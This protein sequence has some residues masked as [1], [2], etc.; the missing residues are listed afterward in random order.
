MVYL[1]C[2]C[3]LLLPYLS[4][5]PFLASPWSVSVRR[6][7]PMM[8]WAIIPP[9]LLLFHRFRNVI[10]LRCSAAEP[11]GNVTRCYFVFVPAGMR[12]FRFAGFCSF[13]LS[14]GPQLLRSLWMVVSGGGGGS[15]AT[16]GIACINVSG[17]NGICIARL[18]AGKLQTGPNSRCWGYMRQ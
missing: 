5:I 8:L 14:T 17:K 4:F 3:C 7:M 18:A 15:S 12:A 10:P 16:H 13:D 11:D 6:T 2:R 9:A 1:S